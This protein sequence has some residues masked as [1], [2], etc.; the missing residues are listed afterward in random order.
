MNF[1]AVTGKN[2]NINGEEE[3]GVVSHSEGGILGHEE[4]ENI[5]QV[6]T[7]IFRVFLNFTRIHLLTYSKPNIRNS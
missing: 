6:S 5:P 2:M 1:Q 3:R 4:E 7:K